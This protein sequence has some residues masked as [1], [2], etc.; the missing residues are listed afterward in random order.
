MGYCLVSLGVSEVVFSF[1]AG[2]IADKIGR[3]KV[4]VIG[5]SILI[6]SGLVVAYLPSC[7]HH[8]VPGAHDHVTCS[9]S[10]LYFLAYV[11]LG[12][13][14]ATVNIVVY[15]TLATYFPTRLPA[16]FAFLRLII[17]LGTTVGFALSNYMSADHFEFLLGGVMAVS[18]VCTIVLHVFVE[19]LEGDSTETLRE[20]EDAR[21]N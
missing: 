14:D 7:V 5:G 13:G 11:L 10:Y 21:V 18:I 1:A 8:H 19:S 15:S 17:A 6:Y 20:I 9:H 4:Y 12:G 16:A 2:M 3:F